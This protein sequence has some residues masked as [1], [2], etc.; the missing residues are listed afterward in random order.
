[1]GNYKKKQFRLN[2]KII[3]KPLRMILPNAVDFI[4]KHL[5]NIIDRF[6][7]DWGHQNWKKKLY[8]RENLKEYTELLYELSN[9]C[10]IN[11]IK[12]L[13]IL[14]PGGHPASHCEEYNTLIPCI[15]K[16]NIKYLNLCPAVG[17]IANRQFWANLANPHP[18]DLLTSIYAKEVFDYLEKNILNDHEK[19]I[20]LP[21]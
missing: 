17:N 13:F 21:L 5:D 1:M 18:G 10:Y 20:K 3:V 19:S 7:K 11:D 15:E 14:T 4:S 9:Y 2:N 16:A 6:L 12:L 8:S